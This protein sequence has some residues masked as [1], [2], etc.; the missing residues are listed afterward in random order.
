[1]WLQTGVEAGYSNEI[2]EGDNM[3]ESKHI[4]LNEAKWDGWVDSLD[5]KGLRSYYLRHGQRDVISILN[6]REGMSILD[7]GCGT[8]WALGQAASLINNKGSFYGVDLSAK[9]IER[10][11]ENF[12]TKENFYFIKANAESIPLDDN[13]F[14]F[15][16]CTNSFHHYFNP[17]KALKEMQRLLKTGGRVYILESNADIWIIKIIDKLAKLFGHGHVKFYNSKEFEELMV[18]AGLKYEGYKPN[19]YSQK[20]QVGEK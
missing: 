17:D 18:G 4:E 13:L 19:R 5:K 2:M 20:V 10:A 11:K 12:K 15:I 3:E 8:G 1:M 14:D 7:I 6:I 16:I 9:M